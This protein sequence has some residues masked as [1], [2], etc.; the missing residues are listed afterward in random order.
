MKNF[1]EKDVN[2][3]CGWRFGGRGVRCWVVRVTGD[4]RVGAVI[5]G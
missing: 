2:A 4:E 1:S 3:L 5:M